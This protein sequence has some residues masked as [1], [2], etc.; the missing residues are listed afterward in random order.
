MQQS[1]VSLDLELIYQADI[2]FN[3][4][5]LRVLRFDSLYLLAK[6]EQNS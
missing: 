6:F 4:G 5:N 1:L 3:Q 2:S